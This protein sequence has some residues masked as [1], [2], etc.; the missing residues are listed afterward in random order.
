MT[1]APGALAR[2]L[3]AVLVVAVLAGGCVAAPPAGEPRALPVDL[4]PLDLPTP[5]AESLLRR[6]EEVTVRIRSLGCDR[7]GV[8]SGFVL[9]GGIVVTNRHV[10]GQPREV[11]LNT[12]DGRSLEASVT[13]V[14]TD[15]DLAVLSLAGSAGLPE[16]ALRTT[17]VAVGEPVVAVGYP[18]GG[19]ATVTP[20][21]VVALSDAVVLGEAAGVV[22]VDAPI[23]QG[24]SGGPLLD[25]G[26]LVV[27]VVF[28]LEVGT[29]RGFA[30]PVP[31]LLERLDGDA[32]IVPSGDC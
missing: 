20:G 13:G 31:T 32:M 12:W 25:A 7:L 15:S 27:G 11:T 29:G 1:T 14:A 30:V 17:P 2:R 4:A 23:R 21:H 8:G 6:A 26:G 24:N 10:V 5:A 16:A 3:A 18:G 9:P 28:A 22:V 19:P